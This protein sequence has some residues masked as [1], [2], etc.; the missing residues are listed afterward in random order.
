MKIIKYFCQENK[1]KEKIRFIGRK[2]VC[3]MFKFPI[4][5]SQSKEQRNVVWKKMGFLSLKKDYIKLCKVTKNS[6]KK[7]FSK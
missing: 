7:S 3:I 5:K 2:E 1:C 4:L 6:E